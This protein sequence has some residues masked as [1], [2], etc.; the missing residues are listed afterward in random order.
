MGVVVD[1]ALSNRLWAYVDKTPGQGPKGKCWEV[2]LSIRDKDGYGC[3]NYK[4]KRKRA[5]RLAFEDQIGEIPAGFQVLH[6][7]DNPPCVRG[8]HL[9]SGTTTD[10]Q[11]DAVKRKRHKESRK[12]HCVNGHLFSKENTRLYPRLT[13]RN[14]RRDCHICKVN[15]A[16]KSRARV[17]LRKKLV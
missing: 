1:K 8:S 6:K 3:F 10:N 2:R 14:R 11:R 15:N 4:G 5:H 13:R 9:Y 7:C 12:T 17:A 16:R